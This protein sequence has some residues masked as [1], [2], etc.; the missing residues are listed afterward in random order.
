MRVNVVVER[1]ILNE[2]KLGQLNWKFNREKS[3]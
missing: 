3:V 1:L 2:P